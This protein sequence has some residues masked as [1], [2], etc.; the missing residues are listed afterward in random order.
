[1]GIAIRLHVESTPKLASCGD[2]GFSAARVWERTKMK[3]IR[4]EADSL[5]HFNPLHF[6]VLTSEILCLTSLMLKD[7]LE[8]NLLPTFGFRNLKAPVE[9]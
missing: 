7:H 6:K 2:I 1:L 4:N 9:E 3:I 8:R 5:T